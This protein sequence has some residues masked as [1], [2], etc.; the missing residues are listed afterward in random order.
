[1]VVVTIA[2]V[3]LVEMA[4]CRRLVATSGVRTATGS[5]ILR[6]GFRSPLDVPLLVLRASHR[7]FVSFMSV[8]VVKLSE[9]VSEVS[10]DCLL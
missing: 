9:C 1:M 8:V 2:R 7:I 10:V 4:A 6:L 5:A 3:C